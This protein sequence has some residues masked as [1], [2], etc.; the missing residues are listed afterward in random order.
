V[1]ASTF[2]RVKSLR[3]KRVLKVILDGTF[4]SYSKL[5]LFLL[6]HTQN[7]RTHMYC[8]FSNFKF[9]VTDSLETL[10]NL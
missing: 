3:N 6:I 5:V 9:L 7:V 4:V 10:L 8:V 2:F 1:H